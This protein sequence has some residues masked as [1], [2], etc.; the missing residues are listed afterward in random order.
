MTASPFT[1]QVAHLLATLL[2][3]LSAGFFYSYEASVTRG[4][5]EVDDLTYVRT[6]QS[7]NETVRNPLF[8]VVF[9]GSVPL[10]LL[11]N[12]LH[13]SAPWTTQRWLLAVAPVLYV[14]GMAITVTGN[15]QLNEELA[16]VDVVSAEADVATIATQARAGFE[17]EWN[18]WNG[19]R[20]I[21]FVGSF[22]AVAAALAVQTAPH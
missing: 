3:G 7:L 14:L 6:F 21:A 4:L 20:T 18:R 16:E 17:D 13:R 9:F 15:V 2:V 11:A 19:W 8:G 12:V 1:Q 22:S 5:T 10:L